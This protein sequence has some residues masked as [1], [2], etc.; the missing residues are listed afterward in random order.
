MWSRL[1]RVMS[2]A[3]CGLTAAILIVIAASLFH[4]DWVPVLIAAGVLCLAVVAAVRPDRALLAVA[5]AAPLATYMLRRWNPGVAWAET[6][7]VAFGAGWFSRRL[8][9][10]SQPSLPAA[11][12]PPLIVFVCVVLASLTVQLSVEQARLGTSE[13]ASWMLRYF[14]RDYFVSGSD[15]YLHAGRFCSKGSCC[16]ACPRASRPQMSDSPGVW[17]ARWPHQRR[18]RR[19]STCCN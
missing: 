16:S 5:A 3:A 15:R 6:L 18:W 1:S 19:R 9:L 4:V 2:S 10:R 7:V 14:S 8:F 12:R 17:Q 13:F 11:L